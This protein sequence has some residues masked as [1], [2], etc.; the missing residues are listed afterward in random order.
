MHKQTTRDPIPSAHKRLQ[1]HKE[2]IKILNMCNIIS[3]TVQNLQREI[4]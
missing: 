3:V 1:V 4:V 2:I